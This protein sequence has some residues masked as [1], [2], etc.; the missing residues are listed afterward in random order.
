MRVESRE[1]EFAGEQEDHGANLG[2]PALTVRLAHIPRRSNTQDRPKYLFKYGGQT[3]RRQVR[4]FTVA[5][6]IFNRDILDITDV[7]V[8]AAVHLADSQT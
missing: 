4:C 2:G 1:V 6:S 7:C 5:R 3:G 8:M